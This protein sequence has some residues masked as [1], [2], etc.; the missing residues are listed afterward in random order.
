MIVGSETRSFISECALSSDDQ[1][2]HVVGNYWTPRNSCAVANQWPMAAGSGQECRITNGGIQIVAYM[3]MAMNYKA[4][5]AH[6]F[7]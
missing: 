4:H 5:H 3:K 7:L 6:G 1:T 2:N